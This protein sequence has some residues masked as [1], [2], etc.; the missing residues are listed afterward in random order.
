ME[1][2][3]KLILLATGGTGGHIFP[4]LA[5]K[6][7]LEQ[8]G[9][10]VMVTADDRFAKF[11]PFDQDHIFIPAA[12][13]TSKSP[14]QI[15]K[16]FVTLASGFFKA[17]CLIYKNKP[18]I[19]MGFGGYITYPT[20]LAA[21]CLNKKIIL[22][23]A[24]IVIGKVNRLLLW[25]ARYLTT[26]FNKIYKVLPK[27]QNKVIYTG[28][29]VREGIQDC[30]QKQ[31]DKLSI[32]IIGGS[33]GAK[34]FSKIIPDMIRNLPSEIKEHL[35]IFQQVKEEDVDLIKEYYAK[36]GIECEVKSFFNDMDKKLEQAN[37]VIAR[38]G[39][40]TIA[41]LIKVGRP[42]I[43]I[44]YPTAADNHQYLNA[45]ILV[46]SKASWIVEENSNS[47]SELIR[48]VKEIYRN[49]EMLKNYSLAIKA[50][51]KNAEEVILQLIQNKL[52]TRL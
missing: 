46:N 35:R 31:S 44:P 28:N 19:V 26:G 27:Y 34:V 47:A 9:F 30:L 48:V 36:E 51:D 39:A 11:H 18:E 21:I 45:E 4:A 22:H 6:K 33:Q 5:L 7:R 38:A 40:S 50:M 29:P 12:N 41:E 42:A 24:N 20:M 8:A 32:L 25:R 23:E 15:I 37:L 16:T 52:S 3:N 17:L 49:P 10:K 14:L 1:K 13:F 43:F 2:H